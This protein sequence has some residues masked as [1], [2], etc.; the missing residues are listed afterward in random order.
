MRNSERGILSPESR[1]GNF[2]LLF[3]LI[4]IS[5]SFEFE[6]DEDG[7]GEGQDGA[8]QVGGMDRP[9]VRKNRTGDAKGSNAEAGCEKRRVFR[10]WRSVSFQGFV[11]LWSLTSSAPLLW[12][13]VSV[14]MGFGERDVAT[15]VQSYTPSRTMRDVMGNRRCFELWLSVS[16]RVVARVAPSLEP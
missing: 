12:L 16:A 7:D 3:L 9:A 6:E 13:L 11:E 14:L 4:W 15:P 1:G 8:S 2:K 10:T 5:S